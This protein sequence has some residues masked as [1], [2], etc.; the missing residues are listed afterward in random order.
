M[1]RRAAVINFINWISLARWLCVTRYNQKICRKNY[2]NFGNTIGWLEI[3]LLE[4]KIC[5]S[6]QQKWQI[7]FGV[8]RFWMR[9][10]RAILNIEKIGNS[11]FSWSGRYLL[12][13]PYIEICTISHCRLKY[14]NTDI[15]LCRLNTR[16]HCCRRHFHRNHMT[17]RRPW[18]TGII[19]ISLT[20]CRQFCRRYIDSEY[21]FIYSFISTNWNKS[22]AR[23]QFT[24]GPYS[25]WIEW[26][27]NFEKIQI[28]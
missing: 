6:M 26:V 13:D 15:I 28:L 1:V 22:Y 14:T 20:C 5:W 25:M 18:T 24:S 27:W 17:S 2:L 12:I 8:D 3:Q 19:K 10:F 21:L 9:A 7:Q 23:L 11:G 4:A 16:R